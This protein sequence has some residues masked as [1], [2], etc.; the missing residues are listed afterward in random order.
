[1]RRSLCSERIRI[2]LRRERRRKRFPSIP[3]SL[4]FVFSPD[5]ALGMFFGPA[6]LYDDVVVGS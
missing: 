2:G 1:M 5:F 3:R 4:G 6:A